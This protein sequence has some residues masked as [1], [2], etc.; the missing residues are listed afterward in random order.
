[1]FSLLF[2]CLH[3]MSIE[4]RRNNYSYRNQIRRGRYIKLKRAKQ[5]ITL[6]IC[7]SYRVYGNNVTRNYFFNR[8]C[9][10]LATAYPGNKFNSH[11]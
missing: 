8:F 7:V 1:M 4:N 11:G 10:E 2:G 6:G 5:Y 9:I 3:E